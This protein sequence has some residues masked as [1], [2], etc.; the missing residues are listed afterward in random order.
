[1]SH[2]VNDHPYKE[3]R[4]VATSGIKGVLLLAGQEDFAKVKF[5]NEKV[6]IMCKI[7][8]KFRKC[9]TWEGKN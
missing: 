3:F 2:A 1:M 9:A 7:N 4:D 6:D 8:S 5:M